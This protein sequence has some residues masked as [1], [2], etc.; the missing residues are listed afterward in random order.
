VDENHQYGYII[1]KSSVNKKNVSVCHARSNRQTHVH[2]STSNT[3]QLVLTTNRNFLVKIEGSIMFVL[4][5]I[6]VMFCHSCH[7]KIMCFEYGVFSAIGCTN[8]IP[9]EDAWI[10]RE[11]N[12]II[13]GCYT[14]RQTWQL[15][16]HDGRWTGVVSN[17]SK[18]IA[19]IVFFRMLCITYIMFSCS[20]FIT[21]SLFIADC[22]TLNYRFH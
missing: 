22:Y 18:G 1:D 14:S 6:I 13:I 21:M 19:F 12:K 9:P 8:L 17:C 11:D 15:R 5:N 10:K 20:V 3:L 4:D 7:V 2:L 16:C